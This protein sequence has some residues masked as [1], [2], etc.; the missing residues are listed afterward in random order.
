MKKNKITIDKKY[1]FFFITICAILIFIM[2]TIAAIAFFGFDKGKE[3]HIYA[4]D[5]IDIL[6]LL[7]FIGASVGLLAMIIF[8]N[9][10][11]RKVTDMLKTGT[12]LGELYQWQTVVLNETTQAIITYDV[13]SDIVSFNKGAEAM[14]GY[15]EA[16]VLYGISL[17]YYRVEDNIDNLQ[18]LSNKYGVEFYTENDVIRHFMN[19]KIL[20]YKS[21][22]KA[23]RKDGT[24]FD[25]E[26]T[27][28]LLTDESNNVKGAVLVG[29]DITE[30]NRW[31]KELIICKKNTLAA[32]ETKNRFFTN[33]SHDLR[34]PLTSVIGFAQLLL[35]D[36][37]KNL[38]EEQVVYLN[39]ILEN[40]KS[41]LKLINII[42]DLSTIEE[43]KVT[44]I[45]T[46]IDLGEFLQSLATEVEEQRKAKNL[47]FFLEIPDPLE[48]IESDKS[49]LSTILLNL[50][51]N[52]IKF[53]DEG[54]ITIR[55]LANPVTNAP[56]QID[57]IDTGPGIEKDLQYKIFEAYHH[58]DTS[59]ENHF[60]GDG[61]G[62]SIAL[63]FARLLKYDIKLNSELGK[64][65]TFSLILNPHLSFEQ[66][67]FISKKL[68]HDKFKKNILIFDDD[69][70]SRY[71]LTQYFEDLGAQVTTAAFGDEGIQKALDGNFDLI[72]VDILM[73]PKDGFQI[74]ESIQAYEKLKNI[75]II[76]ISVKA[77]E[78]KD[79]LHNIKAFI[80][81]PISEQ[82]LQQILDIW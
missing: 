14:F 22:W 51:D 61:L 81:K 69:E 23:K 36:K 13:N 62:L 4:M 10:V 2:S 45:R 15:K 66:I 6:L 28:T 65:S 48:P 74:I 64:G 53:T 75:P 12:L 72:T 73:S 3:D 8:F 7:I 54:S 18:M 5:S 79:K 1:F 43:G 21:T 77:D 80:T 78:V 67:T 31:Q 63:S 50:L 68:P 26:R 34:T 19:H 42:L 9:F 71:L 37:N 60:N 38:T 76:V 55:V 33:V 35:K 24:L 46:K 59:L 49:K 27:L 70:D 57:I 29:S 16:E 58:A 32:Y 39:R 20:I 17:Q 44:V 25:F 41:L 11:K 30:R 40:G 82:N 52:S 47:K 56:E